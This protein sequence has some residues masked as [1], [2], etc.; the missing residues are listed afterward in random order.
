MVLSQRYNTICVTG[1]TGSLGH[2]LIRFLLSTTS[3]TLRVFSRSEDTQETMARTLVDSSDRL[4]FLL[5]DI[6]DLQRLL[7]ALRNVDLVIHTAALKRIPQMEYNPMEAVRTNI[8]G[9][10][11]VIHACIMNGIQTAVFVSSDKACAAT[12]LYGQTK[13][14]GERL[15]L[16]AN[17]YTSATHFTALRYGNVSG[18]R[19]S[20]LPLWQSQ[21]E[22]GQPLTLTHPAMTR[23]HLTLAEAVTYAWY[24]ACHVPRGCLFVPH[25]PAFAVTDLAHAFA[26]DAYLTTTG[27]RPGE[28]LAE[29]LLSEDERLRARPIIEA[30]SEIFGYLIPPATHSWPL[31][32]TMLPRPAQRPLLP[33]LSDSWPWRLSMEDL[34]RR[35]Q[36]L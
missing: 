25:I 16:Q 34:R 27:I 7:L 1:G 29:A 32:E 13:A 14:V 24:T 31:D 26:P 18:S 28:K 12:T 15:W 8:Y 21:H 23:F 36:H 5:G 20:I 22:A 6:R 9:T 33:Y 10:E 2:A 19:G 11:N 3:A 30:E 35:L 17:A 4:R